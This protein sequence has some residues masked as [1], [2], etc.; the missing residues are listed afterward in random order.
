MNCI[1]LSRGKPTPMTKTVTLTGSLYPQ[2][3][4]VTINGTVYT[5]AQTLEVEDGTEISVYVSAVYMN[6]SCFINFNGTRVLSGKG[7]YTFTLTADTTIAFASSG[8]SYYAM[9]YYASIVTS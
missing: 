8:S 1:F 9:Y 7:T 6:S 5:S 2:Y 4:Y 3:A